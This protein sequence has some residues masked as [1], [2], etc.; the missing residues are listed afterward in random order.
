MTVS[1]VFLALAAAGCSQNGWITL[2][3]GGQLIDIKTNSLT[4]LLI[5]FIFG[6]IGTTQ[7]RNRPVMA[8]L[9]CGGVSGW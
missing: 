6:L 5:G 9:H 7:L 1:H 2:A 3:V 8:A 4:A